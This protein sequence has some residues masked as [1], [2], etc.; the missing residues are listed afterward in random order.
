MIQQQQIHKNFPTIGVAIIPPLDSTSQSS[1]LLL[2]LPNTTTSVDMGPPMN[3]LSGIS[4]FVENTPMVPQRKSLI[5]ITLIPSKNVDHYEVNM[6]DQGKSSNLP[7]HQ[8]SN[9]KPT[10]QSMGPQQCQQ[11]KQPQVVQVPAIPSMQHT[12]SPFGMPTT[13]QKQF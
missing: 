10:F 2:T 7:T 1:P 3:T 9:P 11:Q 8:A 12:K 13:Y 5:E 6:M 4:N